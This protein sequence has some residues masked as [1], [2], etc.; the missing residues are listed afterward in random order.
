MTSKPSK[1]GVTVLTVS[2]LDG[3][4]I[5]RKLRPGNRSIDRLLKVLRYG[6]QRGYWL[7]WRITFYDE[8]TR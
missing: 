2:G 3:C 4:G 8:A 7:D 6:V 5:W 1:I